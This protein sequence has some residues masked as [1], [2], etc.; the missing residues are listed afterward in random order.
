MLSLCGYVLSGWTGSGDSI[1]RACCAGG[2]PP[3]GTAEPQAA[4]AY[5]RFMVLQTFD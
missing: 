5:D 1:A 3:A 2:D 4:L